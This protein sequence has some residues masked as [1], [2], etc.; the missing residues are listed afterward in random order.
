MR[1]LYFHRAHKYKEYPEHHREGMEAVKGPPETV[2]ISLLFLFEH[3]HLISTVKHK[4]SVVERKGSVKI[5]NKIRTSIYLT[6][7]MVQ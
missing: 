3:K 2:Y 4:T 7:E 5:L 1:K 6:E